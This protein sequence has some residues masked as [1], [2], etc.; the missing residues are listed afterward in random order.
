MHNHHLDCC[1]NS[2]DSTPLPT[3]VIDVSPTDGLA[4]P[5]VFETR[6]EPGTFVALSHCWGTQARFVLD[7]NRLIQLLDGMDLN[8]LPPTF[9]NTFNVTRAL[10]YRCGSIPYVSFKAPTTAGAMSRVRC[11]STT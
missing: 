11:R 5:K 9:R 2:Q 4:S 1:P 7:S 10:G 6:G 8:G 3:R